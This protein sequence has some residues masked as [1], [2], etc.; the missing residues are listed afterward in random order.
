MAPAW[1]CLC[2]LVMC[3]GV[4]TFAVASSDEDGEV[5]AAG[6]S[7]VQKVLSLI[8][9][10]AG[11]VKQDM[12]AQTDDFAIFAR[13]C[14]KEAAAKDHAISDSKAAV[15]DFTATIE[16]SKATITSVDSQVSD[17]SQQISDVEAELKTSITLREQE[18]SDFVAAEKELV[19]T[20]DSLSRAS[21]ALKKAASFAQLSS[22]DQ[23]SIQEAIEGLGMIIEA[24]WVTKEQKS[25]IDAFL[26]AREDADDG[27]DSMSFQ[28]TSDEPKGTEGILQTIADMQEKAEGSLQSAR[29][30]EME[31]MHGHQLL[32]A[33][34]EHE[35]RTMKEEMAGATS[36]KQTTIELLATAE[37]D[38]GVEQKSLKE[39]E[40]FLRDLKHECQTKAA[41]FEL[42]VKD[43]N[44]EL[45]ALGEAKDILDKKF[46]AASSAMFLQLTS[47]TKSRTKLRS[48]ARARMGTFYGQLMDGNKAAALR[49]VDKIGRQFHSMSLVSL[50]FRASRDPFGKVR[51]MIEEMIAKL[52]QEQAEEADQKAFCDKELGESKKSQADKNQKMEALAAKLGKAES[53]SAKLSEGVSRLTKEVVE[54]D[55]S[56]TEMTKIRQK[57][58]AVF[59]V[60]AK[61]ASESQEACA[62]AIQVLQEYYEG[63]AAAA[64]A[65][66]SMFFLQ[67]SLHA[68]SRSSTRARMTVRGGAGIL[69][70]LEVAESDFATTLA[71]ARA[72]EDAAV[73]EYE[74]MMGENK[75]LKVTK[76]TEAKG[77]E[78]QLKGLRTTL[79]ETMQD[80]EGL[81][82]ELS[83]V[84]DYIDKLKPQCETSAPSAEETKAR[85]LQEIDGLKNALSILEG[86][87]MP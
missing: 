10:M 46:S 29:K 31:G 85:R 82:E 25:K 80:K 63:G 57:E 79:D 47:R 24:A 59:E 14:D 5:A 60:T 30:E 13:Q 83:A 37:K 69:G 78:S 9:E 56:V 81:G 11:K 55:S 40:R 8:D 61:D 17:L 53:A 2:S 54:I 58:K 15:E 16:D 34:M 3:Y 12:K 84:S 44:A 18:N 74:R 65:A 67:V 43:G 28:A 48:K 7:P 38:N 21:M 51:S 22:D 62:A 1:R 76:L 64:S 73:E 86:T 68:R 50:A 77:K 36:K 75:V 52:L 39:T 35:L 42:E 32:K 6:V 26:Q 66:S 4:A 41:S 71:E 27:S 33:G 87:G 19:E 20:V 72:A 70:L 49:E 23:N 45:K